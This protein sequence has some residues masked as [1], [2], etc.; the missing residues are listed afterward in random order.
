M[1]KTE[2]EVQNEVML[3]ASK[4]GWRLFRN[5]VGV[6]YRDDGVP[7]RYGL[8]NTSKRMNQNLKS[9]DLIGIKP[10]V[11]T[12]DMVGKTIGVFV[13]IECKREK[14]NFKGTVREIAQKRFIELIIKFGGLAQ[15]CNNS[16]EVK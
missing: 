10:V 5:N 16:E 12:P 4:L 11:I 1:S 8:A 15:F 9:S 2:T 6:A 13:A 14:W 7:V 3:Q